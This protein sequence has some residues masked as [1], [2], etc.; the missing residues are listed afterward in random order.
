MLWS[1]NL[2]N[3][4]IQKLKV[5]VLGG[6]AFGRQIGH[7]CRTPMN[8]SSTPQSSLATFTTRGPREK[9]M[10]MNQEECSHQKAIMLIPWFGLHISKT[11]KNKFLL[12]S[13]TSVLLEQPVW[14]K[15][16][17]TN[18]RLQNFIIWLMSVPRSVRV[19]INQIVKWEKFCS[20]WSQTRLLSDMIVPLCVPLFAFTMPC[21]L[22]ELTQAWN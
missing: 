22:L 17:D 8:G 7:E 16:V 14:T 15:R 13:A 11:L 6:G 3:V 9:A 5:M 20:P 1:K 4:K 2:T 10:V 18:N 12:L 21:Q 19:P